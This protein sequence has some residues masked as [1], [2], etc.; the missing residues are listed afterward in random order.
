MAGASATL[1]D[2]K[3]SASFGN[4]SGNFSTLRGDSTATHVFFVGVDGASACA[5]SMLLLLE[6]SG[7]LW[8]Y[9]ISFYISMC[10]FLVC[11]EALFVAFWHWFTKSASPDWVQSWSNSSMMDQSSE[12]PQLPC[13]IQNPPVI[14]GEYV[15]GTPKSTFSWD[16]WGLITSS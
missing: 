7:F 5:M 4:V 3:V 2:A 8:I 12:A 16:I 14:P 10:W 1:A 13:D 15:F 11:F 9:C 6:C